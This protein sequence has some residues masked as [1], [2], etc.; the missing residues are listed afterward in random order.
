MFLT[1]RYILIW[2]VFSLI[3]SFSFGQQ[4]NVENLNLAEQSAALTISMCLLN[5]NIELANETFNGIENKSGVAQFVL[6]S[7]TQSGFNGL[8]AEGL[9]VLFKAG[10]VAEYTVDGLTVPLL[11]FA[12][13][14][15]SKVLQLFCKHTSNINARIPGGETSL[16][17]LSKEVSSESYKKVD[18]G[19]KILLAAGADPKMKDLNGK[20]AL[21]YVSKNENRYK[22]ESYSLLRAKM[23]LAPDQAPKEPSIENPSVG[24]STAVDQR[25]PLMTEVATIS[26]GANISAD[27]ITKAQPILKTVALEGFVIDNSLN[28]IGNDLKHQFETLLSANKTITFV[29]NQ[30]YNDRSWYCIYATFQSSSKDKDRGLFRRPKRKYQV[31]LDIKLVDTSNNNKT[32]LFTAIGESEH[33][34]EEI[35]SDEEYKSARSKL[36]K[37]N[38][39]DLVGLKEAAF[40]AMQNFCSQFQAKVEF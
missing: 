3:A 25:A 18:E 28:N 9:E 20:T 21:D 36:A 15:D 6:M 23:G 4:P 1:K 38:E 22:M 16:L 30:S 2:F 24:L 29:T 5:N 27:V 32:E 35:F 40:A 33:K 14:A 13:L 8:T 19:I 7:Y 31:K 26:S 11:P 10:A 34:V 37:N 39:I 17:L 12:V